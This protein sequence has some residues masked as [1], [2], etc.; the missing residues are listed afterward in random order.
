MVRETP[1]AKW[2]FAPG[3][4]GAEFR[5]R[6]M[7]VTWVRGHFKNVHVTLD[8]DPRDPTRSSVAVTIDAKEIWRGQPER[9]HRLRSPDFLEGEKHPKRRTR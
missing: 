2:S 7:M 6:H 3:H 8:F 1:I 9:D 5:A 4:T